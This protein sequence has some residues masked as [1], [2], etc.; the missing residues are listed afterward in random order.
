M[1]EAVAIPAR[2]GDLERRV[3]ELRF[4]IFGRS[5]PAVLFALLGWRVFLNLLAQ[6]RALPVHA[7]LG[8]VFAGPVTTG[9]YLLFCV[10]P[11]GI[12]LVRP[13][14]RARDGRAIA[15]AA[16]LVG[17]TMLLVVGAFPKPVLLTPPAFIRDLA[18][19]LAL[20]AFALGV[21]GLLFL[22]RSLSIIPEARRLVTGGPYRFIRHP[23]YAAEILAAVALVL[24][25]PGLW[26]TLTLVPFIAVQMLRARFEEGLLARIFPEYRPYARRTRKLI[27]LV[28]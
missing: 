28:W 2:R 19:P 17:T 22:R 10:I 14:P 12:Y 3:E 11:V 21:C 24:A 27:P 15:R 6:V 4:L 9:V 7:G 1:A 16:G 26:A 8:D 20:G 18:A 23:L 25:R 13:R 5:L